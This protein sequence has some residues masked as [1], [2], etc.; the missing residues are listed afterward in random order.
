MI[1]NDIG[2]ITIIEE[3]KNNDPSSE[4][5]VWFIKTFISYSYMWKGNHSFYRTK[6]W[7]LDN[8]PELMI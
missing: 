7:V 2:E 4:P 6:K 8:H 1:K 5:T 3:Y